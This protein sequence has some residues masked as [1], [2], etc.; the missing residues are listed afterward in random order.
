MAIKEKYITNLD[1]IISGFL[2]RSIASII[3]KKPLIL[4]L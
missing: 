2:K 3:K 1:E 4:M